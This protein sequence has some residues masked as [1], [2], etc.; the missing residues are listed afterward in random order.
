MHDLETVEL[1]AINKLKRKETPLVVLA[2]TLVVLYKRCVG[3]YS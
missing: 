1:A 3:H 2:E